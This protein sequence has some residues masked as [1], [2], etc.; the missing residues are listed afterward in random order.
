MSSATATTATVVTATAPDTQVKYFRPSADLLKLSADSDIV[1][2]QV[3]H[4][5]MIIY[6]TL[7]KHPSLCDASFQECL[8]FLEKANHESWLGIR[9]VDETD[10]N[11]IRVRMFKGVNGN[12]YYANIQLQWENL[13]P[14]AS[15][16]N[17]KA[18]LSDVAVYFALLI[19]GI[20]DLKDHNKD[21]YGGYAVT[22]GRT[23]GRFHVN[24][25]E[26]AKAGV[27]AKGIYEPTAF[28]WNPAT[29]AYIEGISKEPN[30]GRS[31]P[32]EYYQLALHAF[33]QA[34]K[35]A[36]DDEITQLT[37][38]ISKIEQLIEELTPAYQSVWPNPTLHTRN[39]NRSF[40]I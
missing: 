14:A 19:H 31:T 37:E 35:V 15:L 18:T 3:Y 26:Q 23:K 25:L 24:G 10:P 16:E 27:R 22:V 17:K 39:S 33:R 40:K 34:L 8:L 5:Y 38:E 36:A 4:T 13:S 9:P 29:E 11:N 1:L 2:I 30:Y 6:E 20:D 7:L 28:I 32:L 21:V 12:L